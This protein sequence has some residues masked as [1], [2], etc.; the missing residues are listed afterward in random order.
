MSQ[1]G[2]L[3]IN[4]VAYDLDE[5]T[6]DEVEAIEDAAGGVPFSEI[7]YGSAKGM[8]AFATV[9]LRRTNP[10]ISGEEVGRLRLV[11]FV[12]PDEEMPDL[13][14]VSSAGEETLLSDS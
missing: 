4:G 3:T 6:I 10:G 1:F 13:P 14:P 5:L 9:L 2:T 8:R 7:N 12:Q 11:S